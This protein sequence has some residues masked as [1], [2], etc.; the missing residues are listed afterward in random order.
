M[1][2]TFAG[3]PMHMGKMFIF[4]FLAPEI[5]EEKDY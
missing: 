2:G 3:T 4:Y 1:T 5:I